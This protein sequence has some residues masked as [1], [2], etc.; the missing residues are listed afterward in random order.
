[1]NE[2]AEM[3]SYQNGNTIEPNNSRVIK[4]NKL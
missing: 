3:F 4:V 2:Y 1:M